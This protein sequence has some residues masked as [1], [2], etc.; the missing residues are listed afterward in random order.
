MKRKWS[1]LN[2]LVL[3][4]LSTNI[5][6]MRFYCA[7]NTKNIWK[8]PN[9]N[10]VTHNQEYFLVVKKIHK[11]ISHLTFISTEKDILECSTQT[12]GFG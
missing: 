9:K 7:L 10:V 3:I 1:V 12:N 11:I 6:L 2:P 5:Y 8:I 4:K